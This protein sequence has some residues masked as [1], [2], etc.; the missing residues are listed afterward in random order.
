MATTMTTTS[1]PIAPQLSSKDSSCCCSTIDT[2]SP[3][4]TPITTCPSSPSITIPADI[5]SLCRLS[6]PA[7]LHEDIKS[8]QQHL[9]ESLLPNTTTANSYHK[10]NSSPTSPPH[11]VSPA[12]A[13]LRLP[14]PPRGRN[15][16]FRA[17]GYEH[18][19][20][21]SH[22][23][24]TA[25]HL[26]RQCWADDCEQLFVAKVIDLHGRDVCRATA[27]ATHLNRLRHPNIVE[28]RETFLTEDGCALVIVMEYCEGG[29]LFGHI[30]EMQSRGE[31]IDEDKIV[32]WFGHIVLGLRYMHM[33]GVL[34]CD[35]K[36]TNIFITADGRAK[37]GDFGICK[38]LAENMQVL[39]PPSR[40]E[41]RGTPQYM[42]P[43]VCMKQSHIT[44]KSDCWSL[45]CVLYEMCCL[46]HAF[47]GSTP[48][49]LLRSIDMN[50]PNLQQHIPTHVYGDFMSEMI[51]KLLRKNPESRPSLDEVFD[52][53]SCHHDIRDPCCPLPP[54]HHA[55]VTDTN[56]VSHYHNNNSP[57][58]T[59]TTPPSSPSHHIDA[60]TITTTASQTSPA[61]TLRTLSPSSFLI[62]PGRC[63][64]QLITN[65]PQLRS[66]Q[67]HVEPYMSSPSVSRLLLDIPQP[68]T[69][70]ICLLRPEDHDE[71]RLLCS[72][73]PP[74]MRL[75]CGA[76][77]QFSSYDSSGHT[78]TTTATHT[79][80]STTTP[81]TVLNRHN[82]TTSSSNTT[83]ITTTNNTTTTNN[84]SSSCNAGCCCL[85]D[86]TTSNNS[87][88]RTVCCSSSASSYT[89]SSGLCYYDNSSSSGTS[90]RTSGSSSGSGGRTSG[91]SRYDELSAACYLSPSSPHHSTHQSCGFFSPRVGLLRVTAETN[92]QH[93]KHKT[94]HSVDNNNKSSN[95]SSC[96]YDHTDITRTA[97]SSSGVVAAC[98]NSLTPPPPQYNGCTYSTNSGHACE[99]EPCSCWAVVVPCELSADTTT[100]RSQKRDTMIAR[101]VVG[102]N[103]KSRH[104]RHQS[105]ESVVVG[106]FQNTTM[107]ENSSSV[108]GKWKLSVRQSGIT[109]ASG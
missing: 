20:C 27:E 35:I 2:L 78:T 41:L 42:S 6:Q 11:S 99:R 101:E 36:T 32:N 31:W 5:L 54:S 25:A 67:Q 21:L 16:D 10:H 38:T 81:T 88:E 91:S 61:P 58:V 98:L 51:E 56:T 19:C 30:K 22:G 93:R 50:I 60:I 53:L 79:A 104:H 92:R 3:P 83:A 34:H 70:R 87:V 13:G 59:P 49:E 17:F 33:S 74:I 85:C 105:D 107:V 39:S 9:C 63:D 64:R 82:A 29:D 77:Q 65:I 52:S 37:I 73:S 109:S 103:S 14:L 106:V 75:S 71:H 43:E 90:G 80:T 57:P 28:Y 96:W 18:V 84:G 15:L 48:A 46:I 23:H 26:V 102:D 95:C 100:T 12:S 72:L 45:G 89:T 62:I 108:G 40:G 97:S 4:P 24:D 68:Q 86:A 55:A 44:D 94:Q 47:H 66:Q 7:S 76:Q 8:L 1:P 69:T